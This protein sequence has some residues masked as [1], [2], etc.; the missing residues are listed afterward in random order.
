MAIAT[1]DGNKAT[2]TNE[3]NKDLSVGSA[4]SGLQFKTELEAQR[5]NPALGGPSAQGTNNG[6]YSFENEYIKFNW[7][8]DTLNSASAGKDGPKGAAT[9]TFESGLTFKTLPGLN[10]VNTNIRWG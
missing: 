9:G 10:P 8:L 6:H 2:A 7:C 1:F 3:I 4:T 5:N